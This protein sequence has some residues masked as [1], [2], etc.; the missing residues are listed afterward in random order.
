MNTDEFW[1]FLETVDNH[2]YFELINQHVVEKS[3]FPI[4]YAYAHSRI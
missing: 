4:F 2:H 3:L 1:E